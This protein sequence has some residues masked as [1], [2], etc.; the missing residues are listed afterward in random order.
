M[1]LLDKNGHRIRLIRLDR[2]AC[3]S[4][5]NRCLGASVIRQGPPPTIF[6]EAASGL[7]R[8]AYRELV[9]RFQPRLPRK[10]RQALLRKHSLKILRSNAFISDQVV[11]YPSGS[12]CEGEELIGISNELTELDEV[13]MATPNFVSQYQRHVP[14]SVLPQEWH[15][16]NLGKDG[17]L[18]GEDLN[19]AEA[20]KITRGKPE[21]VVAV[22]DDGVDVDHPNLAGSIW[23]NPDLNARNQ[24]GWDFFLPNDDPDH[25]NPRPK[26]FQLPF[27]QMKGNDIHGTCCAGLVAAGGLKGG[28]VGVAPGC[29]ILPVKIFHANDLASDD[30][31][32]DAIRYAAI[33]ADILSCSWTGGTSLDVRQALEDVGQRR[34]GRGSAVFCA[35]GNG[36]G[37]PVGFPARSSN[38]IAVGASTDQRRRADYSNVGPELSVVAPSSGGVHAIF[39]TDV[40]LSNR[41]LNPGAAERGGADGLHTNSFGGT[42]AAAALAAGVGALVLSVNPALSREELKGLLEATADKIGGGFDANGHSDELGFGR[43]NAGKAVWEAA[44]LT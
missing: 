27:D 42:S 30:R 23:K 22:L 5:A 43:I 17:A 1:D 24:I 44:K 2:E 25:F 18:D 38:A 33:H 3:G 36:F 14:P 40:S 32:A 13:A 9:I 29:R 10:L 11:V 15:L 6:R 34:G 20:W 31:V 37:R 26:K 12:R 41:G 21:I 39:T 4:L 16:K 19:L 8:V 35:S 7:I 28:S